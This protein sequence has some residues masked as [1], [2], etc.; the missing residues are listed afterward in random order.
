MCVNLAVCGNLAVSYAVSCSVSCINCVVST[1]NNGDFSMILQ[2]DKVCIKRYCSNTFHSMIFVI[3]SHVK[4]I[5]LVSTQIE[6]KAQHFCYSARKVPNTPLHFFKRKYLQVFSTVQSI[7][8][9]SIATDT[10]RNCKHSK[11]YYQ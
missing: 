7:R 1:Q 4:F 11:Q 2:S 3:D 9:Q 8:I 5:S 10:H 6:S